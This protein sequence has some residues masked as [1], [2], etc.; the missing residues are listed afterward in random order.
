MP[1]A[2]RRSVGLILWVVKGGVREGCEPVPITSV[3]LILELDPLQAESVKEGGEVLHHHNYTEVEN[4]L[5]ASQT[6]GKGLGS[7]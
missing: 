7:G 1:S 5:H 4:K 6:K 2:K 3:E